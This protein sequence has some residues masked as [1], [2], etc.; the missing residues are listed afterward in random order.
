MKTPITSIVLLVLLI[1]FEQLI[2]Q[3]NYSPDIS[4]RNSIRKE[5]WQQLKPKTPKN[6]QILLGLVFNSN[7]PF[8]SYEKAANTRDWEPYELH[9]A[10]SFF[11][12]VCDEVARGKD[13]SES[14]YKTIYNQ[15][16]SEYSANKTDVALSNPLRQ[17]K[18]DALIVKAFWAASMFELA[19]KN[20]PEIQ[21]LARQLLKDNP[22][23]SKLANVASNKEAPSGKSSHPITKPKSDQGSDTGKVSER[24]GST[25]NSSEI[26]DIILR[27]V[28]MYG[29]N[30]V[31][32]DNEVNVLYKNGDI[33]TNP[34]KPLES[35]NI[36]KSKRTNPKKWDRWKKKGNVI[37][38]TRSRN[39]K[40]YDWNKW[41]DLRP[42]ASGQKIYGKFYT[43]DA[44][45]GSAVI[46]A[47]TVFFDNKGRFAWKTVKGGNTVWKPIF[48]KS[49]TSGT[50]HIN[51]HTITLNYNNG[52]KEAF[53]FGYY[54]K[55]NEHFIIGA[56]H[57][58]PVEK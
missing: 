14:E 8:K 34:T 23:Q 21:E 40:T 50:Y 52:T 57:F 2:S 20:S 30:G 15:I 3:T 48:T 28:T 19:R 49:T 12:I 55:D 41:F 7:E 46:N 4:L 16:K 11:K 18:Y 24:V 39:G 13:Y 38:V 56:N 27:T 43:G 6:Q 36:S 42:G 22:I 35:L 44:F 37:Y 32:V 54:P 9:T 17:K 25:D 10:A 53:F 45:G 31:Y 58:V 51:N 26:A 5:T 1:S 47:S 29:L 33:L